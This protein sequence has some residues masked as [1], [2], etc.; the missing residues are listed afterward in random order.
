MST[1]TLSRLDFRFV[2]YSHLIDTL[3]TLHAWRKITERRA[4]NRALEEVAYL[5]A[6]PL[7]GGLS[8][9]YS[10][11]TSP[12]SSNST[13]WVPCSCRGGVAQ[14]LLRSRCSPPL[15]YDGKQNDFLIRSYTRLTR[16]C[17]PLDTCRDEGC[18]FL[19]LNPRRLL[20]LM[21]AQGTEKAG[22]RSPSLLRMDSPVSKKSSC[23]EDSPRAALSGTSPTSMRRRMESSTH[24][25]KAEYLAAS[26]VLRLHMETA[27]S[28]EDLVVSCC[29]AVQAGV[30]NLETA[31]VL[32][33]LCVVRGL[34]NALIALKEGLYQDNHLDREE[35]GILTPIRSLSYKPIV[36]LPQNPGGSQLLVIDPLSYYGT[37]FT[38]SWSTLEELV[39]IA[40]HTFDS[41]AP[42]CRRSLYGLMYGLCFRLGVWQDIIPAPTSPFGSEELSIGIGSKEFSHQLPSTWTPRSSSPSCFYEPSGLST[43]KL[44]F[45][46]INS[47]RTPNDERDQQVGAIPF[48][49]PDLDRRI[50]EAAEGNTPRFHITDWMSSNSFDLVDLNTVSPYEIFGKPS[51]FGKRSIFKK[52]QQIL[53]INLRSMQSIYH[54]VDLLSSQWLPV[55]LLTRLKILASAIYC[56]KEF[57]LHLIRSGVNIPLN[58]K[59]PPLPWHR[60]PAAE[61]FIVVKHVFAF[62]SLETRY[63]LGQLC[64]AAR[65]YMYQLEGLARR[66][67]VLIT[68]GLVPFETWTSILSG[69]PPTNSYAAGAPRNGSIT[70]S[71]DDPAPYKTRGLLHLPARLRNNVP[72]GWKSLSSI[73][74]PN[75]G[76]TP[77]QSTISS[78][79]LLRSNG[80]NAE[81]ERLLPSLLQRQLLLFISECSSWHH[82]GTCVLT[83]QSA[84]YL[85][86]YSSQLL[87]PSPYEWVPLDTL[88]EYRDSLLAYYNAGIAVFPVVASGVFKE[89]LFSFVPDTKASHIWRMLTQPLHPT[90][91]MKWIMRQPLDG[92]G[93]SPASIMAYV[94]IDHWPVYIDRHL[95]DDTPPTF[96]DILHRKP[97]LLQS[98]KSA[99]GPRARDKAHRNA[100]DPFSFDKSPLRRS[101]IG[102]PMLLPQDRFADSSAWNAFFPSEPVSAIERQQSETSFHDDLV[103]KNPFEAIV[104]SVI[105]LSEGW[106]THDVKLGRRSSRPEGHSETATPSTV[107]SS[108]NGAMSPSP[109][110]QIFSG[111]LCFSCMTDKVLAFVTP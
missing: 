25:G 38:S 42:A 52:V 46:R 65:S 71:F 105:G 77:S 44:P 12:S 1:T 28:V 78:I 43:D 81:C 39:M 48:R 47:P 49:L 83:H 36:K 98:S 74:S 53:H 33:L 37:P 104:K 107:A 85:S 31:L 102:S 62:A 4:L 10:I 84:H 95:F 86:A 55:G 80:S 45:G 26:Q 58:F 76:T 110:N 50:L 56:G 6:S 40:Y 30:T 90:P 5:E 3:L 35:G 94:A 59:I 16:T 64:R 108:L 29:E 96:M 60:A 69:H 34:S 18:C 93:S 32:V 51:N 68:R 13:N 63:K 111:S 91:L 75:E 24:K 23:G 70:G 21:K 20:S 97:P 106:I 11:T 17:I 19:L 99:I 8:R 103:V 79:P 73:S 109:K 100:F 101:A 22:T 72:T 61:K 14:P 87:A 2:S 67:I 92:P 89:E 57:T 27:T 41:D 66:E 82:F 7:G 9:S 15:Q 54:L 88:F